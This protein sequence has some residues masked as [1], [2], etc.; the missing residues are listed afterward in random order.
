MLICEHYI[1]PGVH[2]GGHINSTE[3]IA[4]VEYALLFKFQRNKS[5]YPA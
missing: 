1:L 5:T 2:F 4:Y 3:H